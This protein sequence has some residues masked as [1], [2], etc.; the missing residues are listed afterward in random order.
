MQMSRKYITNLM[1]NLYLCIIADITNC[2]DDDN[3]DIDEVDAGAND[4]NVN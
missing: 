4:N 1:S 2:D 3:D